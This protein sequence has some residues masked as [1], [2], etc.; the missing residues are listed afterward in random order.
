M[1]L[2]ITDVP[3]PHEGGARLCPIGPVSLRPELPKTSLLCGQ[4]LLLSPKGRSVKVKWSLLSRPKKHEELSLYQATKFIQNKRETEC[5]RSQVSWPP[6][7]P[8]RLFSMSRTTHWSN[9]YPW[10]YRVDTTVFFMWEEAE[11]AWIW[12]LTSTH[13]A[14]ES[15]KWWL[16]CR[17]ILFF[18]I[19]LF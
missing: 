15:G 19:G 8:A 4:Q 9:S 1:L 16:L 6:S 10:Q 2:K 11:G 14:N 7:P 3:V 13:R 12:T 5:G 18:P 17:L